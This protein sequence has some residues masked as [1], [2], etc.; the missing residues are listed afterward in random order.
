MRFLALSF[1]C[2]GFLVG[3]GGGGSTATQNPSVQVRPAEAMPAGESPT[4]AD[5]V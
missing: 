5:S 4:S 3:C 2:F 1:V